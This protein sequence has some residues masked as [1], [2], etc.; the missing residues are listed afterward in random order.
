MP[1]PRRPANTLTALAGLCLCLVCV[2]APLPASACGWDNET[3]HAEGERLPCVTDVLL[4]FTT[5]H[6][7]EY[8]EA[9]L[10]A[11]DEALAVVPVW[12]EGLDNKGV[13]LLHLGRLEQAEAVMRQRFELAPEAYAGHANLGTVYTF[14]G[15]LDEAEEHIRAA[16]KIEPDAH[17]GREQLHL[18]FVLHLKRVA[19]DP[20]Q[21]GA[22]FMGLELSQQ[23]RLSGSPAKYKA[24]GYTQREFDGLIAMLT[25]Y[26][27]H[28][29][30]D[31]LYALGDL[32][33]L[34]GMKRLAWTAY[35]RARLA[36]HPNTRELYLLE[37]ALSSALEAEWRREHPDV[38]RGGEGDYGPLGGVYRSKT[39]R[40]RRFRE[41]YQ[42]WE[43]AQVKDGLQVWTE[44]GLTTIYNE[45]NERRPRCK[46]APIQRGEPAASKS[47]PKSA[48]AAPAKG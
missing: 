38:E 16:M 48:A 21:K 30:P 47:S 23:Q 33:A 45:M 24:A 27:A 1:R 29:H 44:S 2:G 37:K 7:R 8:Y 4:G 28:D 22:N 3:Y 13:A 10:A 6:T 19:A 32:L 15:R 17:F 39:N 42:R 18:D 26:G 40:S 46:V 36:G 34:Q 31:L 35:H 12:L 14:M 5:S 20:R 41:K 9:R 43:R 25:V 11:M